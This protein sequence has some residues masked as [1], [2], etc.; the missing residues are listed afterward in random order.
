MRIAVLSETDSA[1]P[2]VA[3]VPETVKKFK[4][5][6]AD[7][8]VQSGEQAFGVVRVEGVQMFDDRRAGRRASRHLAGTLLDAHRRIMAASLPET[9]RICAQR[10]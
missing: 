4:S 9:R 6:G 5:L 8:V 2:R 7:V 3:A 10:S 1:E